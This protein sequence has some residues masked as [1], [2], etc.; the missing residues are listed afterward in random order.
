VTFALFAT[1]KATSPHWSEDQSLG[2]TDG[3]YSTFLSA[4]LSPS[5]D[6]R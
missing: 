1:E 3:F 2:L 6:R 5:E 4:A